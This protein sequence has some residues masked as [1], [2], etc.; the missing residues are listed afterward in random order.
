MRS[1]PFTK[2]KNYLM[3]AAL[4]SLLTLKRM[5]KESASEMEQLYTSIM[6]IHRTLETLQRPVDQ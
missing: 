1:S 5:T 2:I 3:N 4:H 6:Q